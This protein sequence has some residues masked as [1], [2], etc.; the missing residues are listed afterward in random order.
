VI[1]LTILLIYGL[2]VM[3]AGDAEPPPGE[4][5]RI[6]VIGEQWWWRIVYTDA[7]GQRFESANE[8]TIPTARPVEL[9]LSTADVIHSFWVPNLAGKVDM[10]PGRTNRLTLVADRPG[11]SRGQCA[12]YCGGA[13]ALMSLFVVALPPAEFADWLD[14]AR[15]AAPEPATALARQGQGLFLASGCGGCHAI[16]G[17]PAA[18]RIGPD[19]TH[20]GARLS[21]AAGTLANGEAA[22]ARWIRDNQHIK[23]ENRMLP[24]GIFSDSELGAL[25]SYLMSLR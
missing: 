8:L 1:T 24:Y 16:R 25:A 7:A 14:Q 19:L 11:V 23:P 3:R 10:I 18:G 20:V 9:T 2:A 15:R 17:T 21:L 5:V 12:E 22:L 13:H 4:P 6:A